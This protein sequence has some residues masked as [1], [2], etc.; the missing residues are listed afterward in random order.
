MATSKSIVIGWLIGR[1]RLRTERAC[2]RFHPERAASKLCALFESLSPGRGSEVGWF[3]EGFA[4]VDPNGTLGFEEV[5]NCPRLV[6]N[7]RVTEL[8]L[9]MNLFDRE[10]CDFVE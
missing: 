8:F 4:Q 2:H 3:Y 9:R 7:C 5:L 1:A 10:I 6:T